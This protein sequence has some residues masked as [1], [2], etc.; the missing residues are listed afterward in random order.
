MSQLS[1]VA[2]KKDSKISKLFFSHPFDGLFSTSSAICLLNDF[3][4]TP[5]QYFILRNHR[6]LGEEYTPSVYS[7]GRVEG[8]NPGLSNSFT[9]ERERTSSKLER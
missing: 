6:G 2:G 8:S 3:K 9:R 7:F 1:G 4:Q 5:Q